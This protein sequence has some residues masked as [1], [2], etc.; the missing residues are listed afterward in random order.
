MLVA[1]TRRWYPN[2]HLYQDSSIRSSS[3]NNNNNNN[4]N[5]NNNNNNSNN[6]NNNDS[7]SHSLHDSSSHS[8][9]DSYFRRWTRAWHPPLPTSSKQPADSTCG[10]CKSSVFGCSSFIAAHSR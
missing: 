4:N 9:H 3:N 6:N 2:W 10:H 8:L 1:P 5:S 7:S